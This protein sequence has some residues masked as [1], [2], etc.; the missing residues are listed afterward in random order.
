MRQPYEIPSSGMRL[1][2]EYARLSLPEVGRLD[3]LDY[4]ALRRDAVISSLARSE[5]G[6]EYLQAA[7]VREQTEPDRT[8]L[9]REFDVQQ[10]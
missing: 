2:A 7:H 1:V 4:L 10:C 6:R 3:V 8:A 9:R 5:R